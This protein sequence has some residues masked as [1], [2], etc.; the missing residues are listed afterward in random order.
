[1]GIAL[2]LVGMGIWAS[3]AVAWAQTGGEPEPLAAELAAAAR[4][5]EPNSPIDTKAEMARGETLLRLG[6]LDG[7]MATF[8]RVIAVEPN[9]LAAHQRLRRAT[10]EAGRTDE[11]PDLTV[12]L[13]D[14][15]LAAA[16][17]DLANAREMADAR[18]DELLVL[19]PDHPELPRLAEVLG[20]GG[21][22]EEDDS[23]H[24]LSRL[25]SLFG[26]GVLLAIAFALSN[27]R[28]RINIRL[29]AWGIG[30]QLLFAVII[31]WTPPGRWAFELAGEGVQK[32]LS[33]TDH[34]AGFLFGKIYQ[35]IASGPTTGPVQ[36]V[37]G[38][39]GDWV[40]LGLI[41]AFHILPT[42]IFFGSLM[43][44]MFHLGVIQKV[45]RGIAW[46]MT[47]TMGTSGAESLSAAGN[48]FVGQTEAPL[49]I[50]PY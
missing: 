26:I 46:V 31:L 41:F 8:R 15:Y 3:Y 43:A 28:K 50:R 45:V 9:H 1:M 37:D 32:I 18:Y 27:N 35:G 14:L 36:Y 7:A 30:L 17:N 22:G 42:I 49:L 6:A 48:I 39:T 11:L 44:V 20:R 33:F 10:I 34:G 16:G 40:N 47:K 2:L 12:R 19:A 21:E 23:L 5:T 4:P 29:V 38:A 24:L 13:V 25:R